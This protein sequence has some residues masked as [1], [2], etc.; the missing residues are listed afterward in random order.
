MGKLNGFGGKLE[1]GES[2]EEAAMREIFEESSLEA[3]SLEKIA[4]IDFSWQNKNQDLKLHVFHCQNFS[5]DPQESEEMKPAWFNLDAIPY[6]KMWD[7]DKYWFPLFL[8]GKKFKASFLF[9]KNDKVIK[10]NIDLN[11]L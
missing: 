4:C 5:G 3:K 11:N 10:H 7:D 6:K 9:D 2:I 1:A 8:E